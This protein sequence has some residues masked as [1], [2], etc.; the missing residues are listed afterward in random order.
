MKVVT[1][2]DKEEKILIKLVDKK[3]KSMHEKYTSKEE[4]LLEA[5]VIRHNKKMAR[6]SELKGK[7]K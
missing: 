2:T 1:L 7:L 5:E 3:M 4:D 6:L